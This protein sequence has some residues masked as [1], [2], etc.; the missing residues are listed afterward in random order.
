MYNVPCLHFRFNGPLSPSQLCSAIYIFRD[1][2]CCFRNFRQNSNFEKRTKYKKAS[3]KVSFEPKS[4]TMKFRKFAKEAPSLSFQRK[5]Q[6]WYVGVQIESI[7]RPVGLISTYS[8][9]GWGVYKCMQ[10]YN[11]AAAAS[12]R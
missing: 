1:N 8:T 6:V 12:L 4:S 5:S 9:R 7:I 3:Q 2:R 10:G 11:S